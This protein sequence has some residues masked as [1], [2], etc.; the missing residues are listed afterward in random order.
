MFIKMTTCPEFE[1]FLFFWRAKLW[2]SG[3]V[4]QAAQ[5]YG[6]RLPA[7]PSSSNLNF[8]HITTPYSKVRDWISCFFSHS[9]NLIWIHS[10]AS[11]PPGWHQASCLT[12]RLHIHVLSCW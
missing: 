8:V 9:H 5:Y 3:A 11:M 6:V 4:Q 2:T 12:T 10:K 1:H 7:S